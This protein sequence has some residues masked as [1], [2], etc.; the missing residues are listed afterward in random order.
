[1]DAFITRAA[2]YNVTLRR[3]SKREIAELRQR[4]VTI[5]EPF[6]VGVDLPNEAGLLTLNGDV[7]RVH[8]ELAR[9]ETMLRLLPEQ[10]GE[11]LRIK[12]S[13]RRTTDGGGPTAN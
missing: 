3:L 5:S 11:A 13:P 9:P 10:M 7:A 6:A 12:R 8:L 4:G 1:M 2:R